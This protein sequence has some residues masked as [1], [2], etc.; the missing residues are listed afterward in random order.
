MLNT[1]KLLEANIKRYQAQGKSEQWLASYRRGWAA[2][3]KTR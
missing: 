1:S 3:G 2:A